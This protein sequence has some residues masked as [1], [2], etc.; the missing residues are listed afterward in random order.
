[1]LRLPVFYNLHDPS[2]ID[3]FVGWVDDHDRLFCGR[4]RVFCICLDGKP[5]AQGLHER[6]FGIARVGIRWSNATLQLWIPPYER[7]GQQAVDIDHGGRQ[8]RRDLF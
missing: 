3:G 1:M 2:V 6:M 8:R 5:K 4:R 7:I